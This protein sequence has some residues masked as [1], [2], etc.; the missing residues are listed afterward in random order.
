MAW[1]FQTQSMTERL[2]WQ[3]MCRRDDLRGRWLALDQCSYD[4]T[5][6]HAVEGEI[7][8]SDDNLA[9]LCQRISESPFKGCAILFCTGS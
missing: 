1:M 2:S 7:V 5:T 6:G 4:Q 3:E 9:D 8:D